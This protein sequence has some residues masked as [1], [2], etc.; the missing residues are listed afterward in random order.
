M[1][2]SGMGKNGSAQDLGAYKPCVDFQ[3]FPTSDIICHMFISEFGSFTIGLVCMLNI[4]QG[5]KS[6]VS[7]RCLLLCLMPNIKG[8]IKCKCKCKFVATYSGFRFSRKL[9]K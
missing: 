2:E 8:D 5:C 3:H 1:N 6:I 7:E 4:F 9:D